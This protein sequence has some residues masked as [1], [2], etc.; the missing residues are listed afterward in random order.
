MIT[1]NRQIQPINKTKSW[2]SGKINKTDKLL[3]QTLQVKGKKK[4]N[5]L[6][7]MKEGKSSYNPKILRE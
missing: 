1:E 2:L 4:Q 5:P 3:S 6:S 7:G